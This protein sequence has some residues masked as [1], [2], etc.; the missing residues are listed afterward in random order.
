MRTLMLKAIIAFTPI[1][2]TACQGIEQ[3][4][5]DSPDRRYSPPKTYHEHSMHTTTVYQSGSPN[6]SEHQ[7]TNKATSSKES[8]DSITE[9]NTRSAKNLSS[10][11]TA[12]PT[13][14]PAVGQ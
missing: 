7:P 8:T 6:H 12:V 5:T 14:S 11:T 9:V 13:E 10:S 1:I 2:L 4:F 3:L